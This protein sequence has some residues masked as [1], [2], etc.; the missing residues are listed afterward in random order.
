LEKL[1]SGSKR[2]GVIFTYAVLA[3]IFE[4]LA[5]EG[6]KALPSRDAGLGGGNVE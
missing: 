4:G 2:K 3:A 1:R 6:I 5:L